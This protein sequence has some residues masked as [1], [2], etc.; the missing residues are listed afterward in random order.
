MQSTSPWRGRPLSAPQG[1]A[2]VARRHLVDFDTE[3]G[4]RATAWRT[5]PRLIER[6]RTRK[7]DG[8]TALLRPMGIYRRHAW[9][10]RPEDPVV[11][12]DGGDTRARRLHRHPGHAKPPTYC[13]RHRSFCSSA[14]LGAHVRSFACS[15]SDITGANGSSRRLESADAG[16]DQ[17]V[18]QVRAQYSLGSSR[19]TSRATAP[20]TRVEV[21]LTASHL[22]ALRVRSRKLLLRPA[23]RG[24]AD[25]S[26]PA[27]AR[28]NLLA[29]PQ[30]HGGT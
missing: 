18:S 25:A 1:T 22:H 30:S 2:L 11:Y 7:T 6:I 29:Q 13:L 20:A 5:L 15:S 12:T 3:S 4:W 10:G 28:S 9:L 26:R 14:D 16:F 17:I 21:K 8:W 19:P 23:Q 24:A 27:L